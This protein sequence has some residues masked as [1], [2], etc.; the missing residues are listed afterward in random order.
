MKLKL[1]EAVKVYA[2]VREMMEREAGFAFAHALCVAK[3]ALEPHVQFF[4]EKEMGLIKKYAEPGEDGSLTDQEGR[5]K[6]QAD[7]AEEYFREKGELDDVEIELE[8]IPSP[9]PERVSGRILELLVKILD[10]SEDGG[11]QK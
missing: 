10:F 8:K 3:G 1:K 6:V 5:F 9:A 7:K 4:T 11:E 2:A